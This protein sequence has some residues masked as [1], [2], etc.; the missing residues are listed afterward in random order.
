MKPALFPIVSARK[1]L[2]PMY[3]NFHCGGEKKEFQMSEFQMSVY[4]R[5]G[6]GTL[7]SK[8]TFDVVSGVLCSG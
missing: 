7:R 6:H 1:C 5:N 4:G 2:E 8:K 3:Y